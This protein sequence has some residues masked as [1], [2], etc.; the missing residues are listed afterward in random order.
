MGRAVSPVFPVLF[1]LIMVGSAASAVTEV[2]VIPS[3]CSVP[4]PRDSMVWVWDPIDGYWLMFGGYNASHSPP[5]F[6]DTWTYTP[7]NSCP[8]SQLSP[9]TH[10][11]LRALTYYTWD[12]ADGYVLMYGGEQHIGPVYVSDTWSFHGGTWT[13][14]T[15]T[16]VNP[17]L[18]DEG[19]M[20]YDYTDGYAVVFGG[21]LEQHYTWKYAAGVWTRLSVGPTPRLEA[22]MSWDTAD[23]YVFMYGGQNNTT[24]FSDTWSFLH[25]TW[26]RVTTS[27]T[28]PRGTLGSWVGDD[29]RDGYLVLFGGIV[30]HTSN[31]TDSRTTSKYKAGVWTN[32]TSGLS[33]SPEAAIQS[34]GKMGLSNDALFGGLNAS[35]LSDSNQLF[36]W[37]SNA[38]SLTPPPTGGIINAQGIQVVVLLLPLGLLTLLAVAIMRAA[39]SAGRS[40]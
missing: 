2:K 18:Q 25:G 13:N 17:G 37:V 24:D 39:K 28:V 4:S 10:P 8:W 34:G 7:G 6:G 33:L 12:A 26:T 31:R 40:R 14:I 36:F 19:S 32:L 38:W 22:A 9:P 30:N 23:G 3:T 29:T 1:A 11:G 5:Y 16:G 15:T 27:G 20:T 21:T 35:N